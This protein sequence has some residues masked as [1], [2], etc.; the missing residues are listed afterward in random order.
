[1]AKVLYTQ[2][3]EADLLEAWL[4]IA[5]DINPPSFARIRASRNAPAG[6]T[7]AE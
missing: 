6:V 3:A 2:R 1:M 4:Y 7:H 5:Q